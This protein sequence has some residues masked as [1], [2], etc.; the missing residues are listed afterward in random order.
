MKTKTAGAAT[1]Q[2]GHHLAR[3]VPHRRH[4]QQRPHHGPLRVHEPAL[5]PVTVPLTGEEFLEARIDDISLVI[6]ASNGMAGTQGLFVFALLAW[7]FAR[8]EDFAGLNL[9][10]L[11]IDL[12]N[13][14]LVN[15][16]LGHDAGDRVLQQFSRL[17]SKTMRKDDIAVR[18]GGEEFIC[19]VPEAGRQ[20]AFV[21]AERMRARIKETPIAVSAF[22]GDDM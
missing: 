5:D 20:Q 9:A 7:L 17:L 8:A 10:L 1:S 6:D 3:L 16:T 13:F 15:D 18:W 4:R 22:S 21:L 19:V 14:K 11:L 2:D 12:D